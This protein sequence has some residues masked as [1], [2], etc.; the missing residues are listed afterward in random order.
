MFRE[1]FL[2]GDALIFWKQHVVQ[3]LCN[4]S[5]FEMY[6]KKLRDKTGPICNHLNVPNIL[7]LKG[8]D[9]MGRN[10]RRFVIATIICNNPCQSRSRWLCCLWRRSVA[11]WLLRSRVRIPLRACMFVSRVCFILVTVASATNW[12]VKKS[13][14]GCVCLTLRWP[15]PELGCCATGEQEITPDSK[16]DFKETHPVNQRTDLILS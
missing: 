13:S 4:L 7:Q 8:P 11:T 9:M 5:E 16:T 1:S 6:T 14:T 12:P 10:D 3:I 15:G 2:S